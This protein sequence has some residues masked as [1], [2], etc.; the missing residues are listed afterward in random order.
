MKRSAPNNYKICGHHI[1]PGTHAVVNVTPSATS[2]TE[3]ADGYGPHLDEPLDALLDIEGVG[4][5]SARKLARH[6]IYQIVVCHVLPVFHDSHNTRLP[7]GVSTNAL[8][9]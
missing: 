6:L 4:L 2:S 8:C 5:K 1:V 3:R 9:A 7:S